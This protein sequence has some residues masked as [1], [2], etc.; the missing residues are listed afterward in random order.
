MPEVE[1]RDV[2]LQE[3]KFSGKAGDDAGV[4]SGYG[5]YFHNVDSD[6]DVISP[7]AFADSLA[8]WSGRGK[9]PPMLLQHGG[10]IFGGTA[11]D[12]TPVGKWTSMQENARGLKVE[13][14]LYALGT[15]R[16]QY[17]YEGLKEGDFDGLSIGFETVEQKFGTKP[18]EPDRTLT[19]V[20]LWEVSL[21]TF[22]ANPKARITA[23]KSLTVEQSRELEAIL[24]DEGLSHRDAV[25]AIAGLK[26]WIQRDA[27]GPGRNTPRDVVVPDDEREA[28][29]LLQA[30]KGLSDQ[31][32]AEV[33][34]PR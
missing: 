26:R 25:T 19:K 22:P 17:I 7:G 11:D 8:E 33:F 29:E 5:A 30:L 4:F 31:C 32:W 28:A 21:V 13:G 9:F 27:G 16:G 10:G 6:G 18:S 1:R 12:M 3:L 20:N 14:R 23:V 34:R 24:R 2:A 15:D